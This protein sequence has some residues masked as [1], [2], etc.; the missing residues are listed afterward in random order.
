MAYID[1]K[2]KN[3]FK[4]IRSKKIPSIT[5][6]FLEWPAIPAY[7]FTVCWKRFGKNDFKDLKYQSGFSSKFF[8]DAWASFNLFN[9]D[10]FP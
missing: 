10:L 4:K 2:Y 9:L 6:Y 5:G 1:A 7:F 3:D 8:K